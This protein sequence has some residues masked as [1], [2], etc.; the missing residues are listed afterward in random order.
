MVQEF[1]PSLHFHR[2]WSCVLGGIY[3]F[4]EY[5]TNG[6]LETPGVLVIL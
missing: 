6:Q 1:K 5:E 3:L 2:H 4:Q